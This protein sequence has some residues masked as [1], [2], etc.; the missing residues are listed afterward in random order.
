M[1]EKQNKAG[2]MKEA[3][4]KL[5]SR[6]SFL[7]AS[8]GGAVSV[9]GAGVLSK[10]TPAQQEPPPDPHA[11]HS[12]MSHDGMSMALVGEVDH[13]RNGFDPMQMLVDWDYGTVSTTPDGQTVR[14]YDI[15]AG[16][17]E[18][19]IA[20]GIFFPAWT[21]N[22]RVPGPTI[23]CTEGDLIRINFANF[24]SHPHTMHFHGFHPASMDGVPGIGAGEI[25]PGASTVYEFTAEPFGCHLYHCHAIPLKRHIHKGL[26][27]AFL[28]DPPGGRP[29]AREFMMIMNGFDTNFDGGNEIYAVNTVGHEF[30][31][32]PIPVIVG[33][34]IRIYLI[35]V[36]EFDLINSFHVHATFFD[37]YDHGTTLEPTSR[38]I[39]TV[40]Q[41]QGQ[42]GIL[43]F[44]FRWEGK[45]MFHAHI[46]EFAEL[47][48]MGFFN[49]VQPEDYA[50]ALAEVGLDDEWDQKATKGS[51]V[52]IS[53]EA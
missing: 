36:L 40:I 8:L 51:T 32:R 18:I 15:S 42:R 49:A 9:V 7:G 34:T 53:E 1:M 29:P 25:V 31:R 35:N 11:G 13:E 23:R 17:I 52:P 24:G 44:N 37:Y 43:E 2:H 21:Y 50:A 5:L 16:D 19:E 46:S 28:V 27:G 14:E 45:Y 47:G 39:D 38:T 10:A 12:G 41:A 6:R 3:I 20:P 4:N 48:W 26:Y 22:G 30:M 33:E